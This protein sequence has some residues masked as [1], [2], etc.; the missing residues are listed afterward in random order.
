M[1]TVLLFQIFHTKLTRAAKTYRSTLGLFFTGF[2]DHDFYVPFQF[3]KSYEVHDIYSF[4]CI[5]GKNVAHIGRIFM[6]I[7]FWDIK[8][9]LLTPSNFG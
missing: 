7:Y 5:R 1:A 8:Y 3:R 9:N 6:N 4:V 2:M